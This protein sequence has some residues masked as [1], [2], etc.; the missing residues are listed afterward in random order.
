MIT[1][2]RRAGLVTLLLLAACGQEN[3]AAAIEALMHATWDR[4]D[5]PL[6]AG[7]IVVDSDTAI[8]DWTQGQMGGRALLQ[9]RD[10]QWSVIL[11]AGDD[12]RTA[13]GLVRAGISTETSTA[14]AEKLSEAERHVAPERLLM[15]SRFEGIMAPPPA[16][17][18]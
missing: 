14:L 16:G 8:A 12:L 10:G 3:D 18:S 5:A 1:I 2:T 11:C 15:I 7:P 17:G 4:P 13:T 9:K 6:D